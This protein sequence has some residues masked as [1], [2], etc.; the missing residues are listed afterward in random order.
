MEK[1][2]LKKGNVKKSAERSALFLHPILFLL[3]DETL[4]PD[5]GVIS[6]FAAQFRTFFAVDQ[7]L[8]CLHLIQLGQGVYN[9]VDCKLFLIRRSE[10]FA[11]K[12]AF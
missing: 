12:I 1:I 10:V 7:E 8:D 9:G 2:E 11:Y 5:I 4:I 6:C 3:R